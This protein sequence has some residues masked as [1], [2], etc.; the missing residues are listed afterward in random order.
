[1]FSAD[2]RN[3]FVYHNGLH[4]VAGDPLEIQTRLQATNCDLAADSKLIEAAAQAEKMNV[5][6]E[7]LKKTALEAMNRMID[8]IRTAFKI[9]EL[10]I[11]ADGNI[12]GLTIAELMEL[13]KRFGEWCHI[14]KKNLQSPRVKLNCS[15]SVSSLGEVKPQTTK[16]TAGS[17][18]IETKLP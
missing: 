18:C 11:L 8:A 3:I 1:M 13:A 2:E 9:A 16:P 12:E 5:N 6:S 14:V 15:E 4:E 10:K 7:D 17:T